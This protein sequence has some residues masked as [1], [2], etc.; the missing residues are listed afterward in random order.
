MLRLQAFTK[1]GSIMCPGYTVTDEP[2]G[3]DPTFMR[4]SSLYD[5]KVYFP[6]CSVVL[7]HKLKIYKLSSQ[8]HSRGA[9]YACGIMLCVCMR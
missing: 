3:T 8:G 1:A 6:S 9:L 5:G 4:F 2:Y 7:I